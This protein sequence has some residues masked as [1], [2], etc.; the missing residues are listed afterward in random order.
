MFHVNLCLAKDVHD[1]SSF[2]FSKETMKYY[3]RQFSAAVV[4]GALKGNSYWSSF[5]IE[6]NINIH[7]N[8]DSFIYLFIY[9][10][11]L[12]EGTAWL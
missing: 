11:I 8:T 1:I 7:F 9:L 3:S 5:V 6:E 4:I 2:I 12:K 10:F